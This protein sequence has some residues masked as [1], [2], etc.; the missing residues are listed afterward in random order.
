MNIVEKEYCTGC[1]AC[2][3]ICPKNAITMVE[4]DEGFLYPTIN[5]KCVECGLCKKICPILKN[6]IRDIKPYAYVAINNDNKI[7]QNSSSGGI[8]L[9]LAKY[10]VKLGGV[11][12]GASFN[13][14]FEV[15]HTF[16]EKE[17]QLNKLQGSKYVQSVIGETYKQ[18]KDFLKQDRYVLFTGTPCQIEGLKAYLQKDYDKLYTQ[19]IICHGVPSPKVWKKYLKLREKIDG[20]KASKIEFRNKDN[21]WK[22]FNIKF[23]YKDEEYKN[24]QTKD[25]FMQSFLRNICLRNSCY[26]CRFKKK[27]RISDIT[28]ADFWGIEQIRPEFDDDNGTSLVIINST[29]GQELFEQIKQYIRYDSVSLDDSIKYNPSMIESVNKPKQ[30]EKFFKNLDKI[31]LDKLIKK[32]LPKDNKIK[33]KIKSILSKIKNTFNKVS[34]IQS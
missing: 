7:R 32:Y 27:E 18:V 13:D 9:L 1:G 6:E 26:N 31:E 4:N 10:V 15:E 25:L 5:S 8:F 33:C 19:D 24:N 34:N 17:E 3:N 14:K 30:R 28:L 20:K 21:G 12:F 2:Y 29:K 16:I 22:L 23:T 11:A